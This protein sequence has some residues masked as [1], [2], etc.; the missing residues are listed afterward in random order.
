MKASFK[1]IIT[2]N[3]KLQC[4]LINEQDQEI[5]IQLFEKQQEEYTPC[6]CYEGNMISV[7]Q[8]E[9]KSI[10]F[11]QQ[12]IDNPNEFI[13]QEVHFQKK[14][15]QVLPEILFAIIINEFK[16]KSEKEYILDET[17][18]EIPSKD[19]QINERIK[20]SLESIGLKNVV[21]NPFDYDYENQVEIL[22]E[23]IEQSEKI[24]K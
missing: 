7:C 6:I 12:W 11:I 10:H 21:V 4:S 24:E 23:M 13:K 3:Y 5:K 1:I 14:T 15:F 9:E 17:I 22:L 2:N 18:V 19:H 8:K 20:K 16:K